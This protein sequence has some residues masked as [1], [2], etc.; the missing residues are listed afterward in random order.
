MI[1]LSVYPFMMSSSCRLLI[2]PFIPPNQSLKG[3]GV[4]LLLWCQ[5]IEG[6][7]VS[8]LA[9]T[10]ADR[11]REGFPLAMTSAH[12][13]GIPFIV[14]SQEGLS[15]FPWCQLTEGVSLF[16]DDSSSQ[17]KGVWAWPSWIHSFCTHLLHPSP[18]TPLYPPCPDWWCHSDVTPG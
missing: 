17:G 9:M 11:G 4:P 13:G 3:E 15:P 12:R 5:P 1:S 6:E 2:G 10:S 8:L 18:I 14:P 16:H 7:R